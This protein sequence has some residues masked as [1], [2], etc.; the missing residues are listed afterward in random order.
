MN[1]VALIENSSPNSEQQP[2]LHRTAVIQYRALIQHPS[3]IK[4]SLIEN[5][6]PV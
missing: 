1:T 6:A 3:L 2:S 5:N 4:L